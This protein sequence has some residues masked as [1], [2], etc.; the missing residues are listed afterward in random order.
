MIPHRKAAPIIN[1]EKDK[2]FPSQPQISEGGK[3]SEGGQKKVRNKTIYPRSETERI[4]REKKIHLP[5]GIVTQ[6]I[7]ARDTRQ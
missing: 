5:V 3:N 2:E 4:I 1:K 6:Q 7:S